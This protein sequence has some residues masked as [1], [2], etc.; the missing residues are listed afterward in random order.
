MPELSNSG[1]ITV[2]DMPAFEMLCSSFGR[3]RIYQE[4]LEIDPLT[5]VENKKGGV[6]AQTKQMNA[7]F[8]M[9]QKLMQQFGL[10]PSDR[11]RLGLTKK[12]AADPDTARMKELLGA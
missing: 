7:E 12:K 11:N 1:V 2:A 3:F 5:Q 4:W 9:C 6:A 10:T 8:F